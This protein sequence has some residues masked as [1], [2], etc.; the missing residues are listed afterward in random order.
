MNR[1]VTVVSSK[2]HELILSF[3]PLASPFQISACRLTT[4]IGTRASGDKALG[5]EQRMHLSY[6]RMRSRRLE[7]SSLS[8]DTGVAV[9]CI[10]LATGGLARLADRSDS[11]RAI[12]PNAWARPLSIM[13][14]VIEYT[15]GNK[16]N[17]ILH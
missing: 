10:V 8:G 3:K 1:S 4:S 12:T 14:N 6:V 11:A 16:Y 15:P 5:C 7:S 9:V 13:P 2:D 17:I